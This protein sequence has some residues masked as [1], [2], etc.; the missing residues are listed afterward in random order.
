MGP[1]R[2]SKACPE[3]VEGASSPARPDHAAL[4]DDLFLPPPPSARVDEEPSETTFPPP[5]FDDD[6]TDLGSLPVPSAA[7]DDRTSEMSELSRPSAPAKSA[8][9]KT[10][11]A[12]TAVGLISSAFGGLPIPVLKELYR[13]M[14][15]F[16]FEPGEL[17]FAAGEAAGPFYIVVDGLLGCEEDGAPSKLGTGAVLGLWSCAEG[18]PRTETIRALERSEVLALPPARLA[19]LRKRHADL[20]RAVLRRLFDRLRA[21]LAA[22]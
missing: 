13:E 6:P 7:L 22:E 3:P 19:L 18:R 11:V 17:V 15:P 12:R 8:K 10:D 20:D 5:I 4:A 16:D 1:K 14:I 2:T 9:G 21:G